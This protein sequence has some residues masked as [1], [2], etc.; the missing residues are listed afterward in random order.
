MKRILLTI[1]AL[2]LLSAAP[3]M[4]KHAHREAW[5]QAEW[6]AANGGRAEVVLRDGS[7]VD[8]VTDTH[9]VEFDFTGKWAESIGQALNYAALT[10]K[11]GGIVLI[12][13]PQSPGVKRIQHLI[14]SGLLPVDLWTV[15]E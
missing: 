10:G 4:A 7:R 12:G 9:A 13:D 6:C 14:E 15:P 5:Y 2:L 8:C 3:A 1:P 11:R